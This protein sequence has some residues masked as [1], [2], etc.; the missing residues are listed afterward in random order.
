MSS[1]DLVTAQDTVTLLPVQ[2]ASGVSTCPGQ[3]ITIN[4][5]IV[6]VNNIPGVE[7]PTITWVYRDIRLIYRDGVLQ[8]TSDPLNNGVYTA[9]FSYSHFYVNSVATILNVP[10]SHH[11]SSIRCLTSGSIP[12]QVKTK[13]AGQFKTK[14]EMCDF[15]NVI[16]VLR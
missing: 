12:N 15:N 5:T 6:R 13:I 8:P 7:Q 11:N 2:P 3:D 1:S 10:L 14:M 16:H 4:C 9:V